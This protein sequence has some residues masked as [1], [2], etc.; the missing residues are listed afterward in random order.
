MS[1][2]EHSSMSGIFH[3]N[4][5]FREPEYEYDYTRLQIELMLYL[6][7]NGGIAEGHKIKKKFHSSTIRGLLGKYNTI[8][9]VIFMGDDPMSFY[10]K[11]FYRL[12]I[13]M[14]AYLRE[15]HS[16]KEG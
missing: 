4:E 2:T 9:L 12:N 16:N 10:R 1:I 7:T 5:E 3:V 8:E 6:Y 13:E 11:E 14:W 15:F